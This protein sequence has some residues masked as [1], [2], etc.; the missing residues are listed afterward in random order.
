MR[1]TFKQELVNY[2]MKMFIGGLLLGFGIGLLI[3]GLMVSSIMSDFE[4]TLK[5]YDRQI[6]DFYEFTHSYSFET[7]QDLIDQVSDFYKA[8]PPLRQTLETIGM[9]QVG[10]LLQDIDENLE[11]T[12]EMSEDLYNAK[13]SVREAR[14]W[15]FY[16][17]IGGILLIGAGIAVAVWAFYRE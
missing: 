17:E 16:L 10:Q 5:K 4:Y 3:C 15:I 1:N 7:V 6:D 8:N 9:G 2:S 14:S 11:D 13:S 12:V